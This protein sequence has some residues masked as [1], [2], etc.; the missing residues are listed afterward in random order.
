MAEAGSEGTW[1]SHT[2][3]VRCPLENSTMEHTLALM[4]LMGGHLRR[5]HSDRE[6]YNFT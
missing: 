5:E 1:A 6:V 4:V 3:Q 2:W